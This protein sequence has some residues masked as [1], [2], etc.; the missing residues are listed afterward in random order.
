[1]PES[2]F[3]SLE[4]VAFPVHTGHNVADAAPPVQP[5]MEQAQFGFCRQQEAEPDGGT[6]EGATVDCGRRHARGRNPN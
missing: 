3:E 1:M 2:T 5:A 6:D 4:P